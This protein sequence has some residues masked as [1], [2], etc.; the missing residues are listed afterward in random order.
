MDGG[1][2][3]DNVYDVN[4][5]KEDGMGFRRGKDVNEMDEIELDEEMMRFVDRY[6]KRKDKWREYNERWK[7]KEKRLLDMCKKRGLIEE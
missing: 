1:G 3:N 4:W 2:N 6:R 7:E 5:M